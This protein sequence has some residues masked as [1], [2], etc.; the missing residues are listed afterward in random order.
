MIGSRFCYCCGHRRPE[1]H[2]AASTDAAAVAKA[3]TQFVTRLWTQN[4]G[5]LKSLASKL[6][7]PKIALPEWPQYLHFHEIK[8]WIGLPTASMVAFFVGL[9]CAL[10]ALCAGLM[11]AKTFV[12]WEAVQFYRGEWLLA[13][14]ASFVAGILLK[15]PP[16][17]HD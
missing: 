5:R 8:R 15:K 14:T 9:G 1:A 2:A 13:A 6:S 10:A 7:W 3:W 16:R 11:T 12:D 17:N 4:L